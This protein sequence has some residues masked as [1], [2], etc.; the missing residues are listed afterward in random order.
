LFI[1]FSELFIFRLEIK[2]LL[3]KQQ[4]QQ[5]YYHGERSIWRDWRAR[6]VVSGLFPKLF[7]KLFLMQ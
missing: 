1:P 6:R 5:S 7:P 2:I 4:Q 3:I